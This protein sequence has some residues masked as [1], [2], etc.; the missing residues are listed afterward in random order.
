[1]NLAD[2]P[3][4]ERL[5]TPKLALTAAEYLA[6]THD[7]H[8]LV[9]LTDMTNMQSLFVRLALLERG[10]RK[11]GIPWIYVYRPCNDL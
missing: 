3:A 8:V 4:V 6:F 11:E 2:D 9:I 10:S 1:M 5:I 7:M